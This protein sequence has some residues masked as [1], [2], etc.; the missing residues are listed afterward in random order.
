VS[1]EPPDQPPPPAPPVGAS[2]YG[3]FVGVVVVL[4]MGYILINTLR[5]NGPGASG[6]KPGS[7]M[8]PFAAPL[9]LSKLDGDANVA[10]KA[11]QGAAGKIPACSVHL[12]DALNSCD[13]VRGRPLVLG[14][15]FTRG[16]HCTGSFD[17]IQRLSTRTP[18][19]AFAG[20]VVRGDRGDARSVVRKHHW[21]FPIAYDHD[22]DV[23]DL[24][25]I[26]GCPEVVLAYPG[27]IVRETVLGR[28]RAERRL[29][30]HVRA[31][32]TAS[33]RRGWKMPV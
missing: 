1:G 18:G 5:T 14:F 13:L 20:I 15:F 21:S 17:V 28:D 3:W 30:A 2:R 33:V 24:Y 25:G 9:L 11:N 8:H 27:G 6:P 32:V 23:A 12:P 31:L 7:R 22:G 26:A 19:V 29:E 4:I 16:A 10:M